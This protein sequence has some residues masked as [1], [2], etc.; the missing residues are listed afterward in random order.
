[1]TRRIFIYVDYETRKLYVSPEFNGDKEEY[2]QRGGALDTCDL[3]AE[4]LIEI[5]KVKTLPDFQNA[6]AEAQRRYHSFLHEPD[7]PKTLLPVTEMNVSD[8]PQI[9][10]DE[11]IFILQDGRQVIAPADWDGQMESLYERVREAFHGIATLAQSLN[12]LITGQGH[13]YLDCCEGFMLSRTES[14]IIEGYLNPKSE[15][16][17]Q[18]EDCA[19]S[20]SVFF[21]DGMRMDI[22]CCGCKDEPS[23]TEAVLCD[24]CGN[25]V[26]GTDAHDEFEGTWELMHNGILYTAIVKT[27][28][29]KIEPTL[30]F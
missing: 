30:Y 12:R 27:E 28:G 4:E 25:E 10:A 6:A 3:T 15:E 19:I 7:C 16:D 5:F 2:A 8:L 11:L 22:I 24:L 1:M 26:E 13:G 9:N 20:K 18:G 23:W 21:P 17:C 29:K 14:D